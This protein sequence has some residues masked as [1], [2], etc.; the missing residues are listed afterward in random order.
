[1]YGRL[2]AD[3]WKKSLRTTQIDVAS[4]RY[5]RF[6]RRLSAASGVCLERKRITVADVHRISGNECNRS[7]FCVFR[8]DSN[9][10]S[11]V[12]YS[13]RRLVCCSRDRSNPNRRGPRTC[14]DTA[15]KRL[16]AVTLSNQLFDDRS[17]DMN[18]AIEHKVDELNVIDIQKA[19]APLHEATALPPAA[20]CS[21]AIYSLEEERLFRQGWLC[22]GRTES[23]RTRFVFHD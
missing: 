5:C 18:S 4:P 14:P 11:T 3:V 9:R 7:R 20:Y 6:V 19:S 21:E 22:V 13:R 1:M 10:L 15:T 2:F 8:F 17:E 23:R 12:H 16:F